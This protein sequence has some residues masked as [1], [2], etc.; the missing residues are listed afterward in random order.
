MAFSLQLKSL[1]IDTKDKIAKSLT[2]RTRKTTFNPSP[3]N[4]FL[5]ATNSG[6]I[7]LPLGQWSKYLDTFPHSIKMYP[8]TNVK[9]T[10]KLYTLKTD[11]KRK[12]DQNIVAKEAIRQLKDQH[13]VFI[14]CMTG[15]GKCLAPGTKVL[16]YN[17]EKKKVED[18]LKGELI[19]GDDSTPRNILSVCSGEE[20]M[21]EIIPTKGKSFTVN[22]SHILTLY[23]SSQGRI[24]H[25]A[26]C[27]Y[28]YWFDGEKINIKSFDSG[29]DAEKHSEHIKNKIGSIFDIEITKYQKFSDGV[30]CVL[31]QFYVPVCYPPQKVSTDPYL[32]GLNILDD[33]IPLIYKANSRCVRMKL[34][35]GLLDTFGKAIVDYYEITQK[36]KRLAKD[37]QDVCRSLGFM[38]FIIKNKSGYKVLFYNPKSP[39]VTDFKVVSKGIGKYYGF[40]IDGNHRFLLGSHMV[41]HNTAMG[42]YLLSKFKY[43]TAIL[44]HF[45]TV[46]DQWPDEIEKFTGD[47]CKVQFVKGKTPLDPDVDVYFF[48]I[49]KAKKMNREDV[50]H[51]GMVI[52]DEAHVCTM[53]AFTSSLLKFQP[54]YIIGLS[55]TPDRTDGLQKAFYP[56]FGPLKNFICR[57][58]TKEFQV[59]KYK[60]KYTPNKVPA[61]VYGK[62]ITDWCEVERSIGENVERQGEIAQIIKEHPDHKIIVLCQR[63]AC[64]DG[65]ADF[66]E[67]EEI[68]I[69]KGNKKRLGTKRITISTLRKGGVGLNDPELTMMILEAD[70]K[71][72]RQY[73]GRLRTENCIIYDIVDDYDVI[74]PKRDVFESHWR[75]REAW[76]L[77]RG[78]EIIHKGAKS[79]QKITSKNVKRFTP[80]NTQKLL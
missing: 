71:D 64:R 62:I 1:D 65:I 68:E 32:F 33:H 39:L 38:C 11:P 9:F 25:Y 12:R 58:E 40:C 8:R 51:I 36:S 34:L 26:N 67:K 47:T 35:A 19:M 50:A 76:Y 4:L 52:V 7:Y 2:I 27:H 49:Q 45:K 53:A 10:K 80:P 16:M 56:Y 66:F 48:G 59:I 23:A 15:F 79:K 37:I 57:F 78:A 75:Q 13:S 30:K 72:T 17:G 22:K 21:F 63:C 28:V 54:R 41:T 44:C 31:K 6:T 69:L 14:S 5:F 24:F 3:K 61:M 74:N 46:N 20:E 55:A 18:I 70:P 29:N 42:I 77:R 73:E 43:K 60:T